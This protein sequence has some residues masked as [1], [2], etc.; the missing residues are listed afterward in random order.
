MPSPAPRA[1]PLRALIRPL[2]ILFI[3]ALAMLPLPLTTLLSSVFLEKRRRAVA[4]QVTEARTD[5]VR[6]H[7]PGEG[8]EPIDDGSSR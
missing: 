7:L 1:R 4:T 2:Q 5:G 6:L 8:L 3:L